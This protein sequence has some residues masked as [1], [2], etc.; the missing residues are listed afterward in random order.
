M[1]RTLTQRLAK[2]QNEIILYPGHNYGGA[3]SAP[4]GEVRETNSY[5]QIRRLEDWL[6]VMGG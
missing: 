3:A 6:T 1:Y 4:L 5:L 2:I